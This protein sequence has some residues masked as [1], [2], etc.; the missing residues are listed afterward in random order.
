MF[1]CIYS[2]SRSES[3]QNQIETFYSTKKREKNSTIVSKIT[4]HTNLISIK[5]YFISVV[6]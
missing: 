1:V 6:R 2:K 4:L 5:S 3:M